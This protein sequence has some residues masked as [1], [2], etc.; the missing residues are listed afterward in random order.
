MFDQELNLKGNEVF[1][2]GRTTNTTGMSESGLYLRDT[3]FLSTFAM[4]LNGVALETLGVRTGFGRRATVNL[5]NPESESIAA[6]AHSISIELRIQVNADVQGSFAVQNFHSQPVELALTL[7]VAA[8]FLDMFQVRGWKVENRGSLVDSVLSQESI[9][10]K[11]RSLA[12]SLTS[13]LLAFEPAPTAISS[14]VA[15]TGQISFA[16]NL[17]AGERREIGFSINL[18]PG[19]GVPI[20]PI[21]EADGGF[22]FWSNNA[23]LQQ[24]IDQSDNDLDLLQT[25]TADGS[26]PAAGLPWYIAPF[27]RDSLIVALQTMHVYPE[28]VASTLRVLAAHQG[29]KI[30][31]FHEEQPGKILHEL[32]YGELARSGQIPHT[33]YYGSIDSTPLFVLTFAQHYLWH[34]DESIWTDLIGPVK[35]A[36]EWITNYGDLDGDGLIE[37][38][39]TQSDPT[40]ISQQGWKDSGDSLHHA[41]GRE[42]EGPIALVEVQGYVFGAYAWLSEAARIHGDSEW[43]DELQN[44]AE[45]IRSAVEDNYW[46]EGES[47]YAQALDGHKQRVEAI[48]SNPGHLLFCGLPS[49]QRAALMAERLMQDDLYAG[50]GIRTLSSAMPTYN[51]MSYHNGSIWPHDTS[52]AM[53]GLRDYGLDTSAIQLAL[54]IVTLGY[55]SPHARLAELYCGW[56]LEGHEDGPVNYPVSCSPQAWAAASAHLVLRTLL[57][58]RPDFRTRTIHVDPFLPEQFEAISVANLA[59]FGDAYDLAV[60]VHDDHY[61]VSPDGNVNVVVAGGDNHDNEH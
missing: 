41:D 2:V 32:R 9:E 38:Q 7:D 58:I 33:P 3:R 11:Y 52:L 39:G 42:V 21:V 28:R 59:A 45:D 27:G 15:G 6:P 34:R 50:W 25:E 35:R 16:L 55:F 23:E 20:S 56:A 22:A 17:D 49:P 18:E 60:H 10:L 24:L 51:P 19:D 61:H 5:T 48:S 44:K 43:S 4:Q 46:I 36:L 53:W 29:T 40:H 57:G 1:L 31:V 30:D 37:Y 54:G 14:A 8:D 13:T 12:G 26:I 47:F